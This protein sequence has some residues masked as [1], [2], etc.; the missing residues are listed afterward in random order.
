M[1]FSH[2]EIHPIISSSAFAIM[3]QATMENISLAFD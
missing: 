1:I 2:D 3:I